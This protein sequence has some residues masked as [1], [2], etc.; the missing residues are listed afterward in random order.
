MGKGNRNGRDPFVICTPPVPAI[1]REV[2]VDRVPCLDRDEMGKEI[3]K[4]LEI[5]TVPP[6][7]EETENRFLESCFGTVVP[8]YD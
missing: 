1:Y 2:V 5:A 3:P 8:S 6:I 7:E 4:K